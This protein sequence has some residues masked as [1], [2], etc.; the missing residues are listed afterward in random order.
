MQG[1]A[2]V[3]EVDRKGRARRLPIKAD[4]RKAL[5]FPGGSTLMVSHLDKDTSAD[6]AVSLKFCFPVKP[7][8]KYS[9]VTVNRSLEDER[10][11]TDGCSRDGAKSGGK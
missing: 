5:C 4:V 10:L 11:V 6:T 1:F 2:S 9:L 8:E 3:A 7:C